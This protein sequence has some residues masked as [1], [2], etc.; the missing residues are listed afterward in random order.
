MFNVKDVFSVS[1]SEN[2]EN[3]ISAELYSLNDSCGIIYITDKANVYIS[4][5]NNSDIEI[6][7]NVGEI[8]DIQ[9][10]IKIYSYKD[11]FA[12]V[13]KYSIKGFVLKLTD[14]KYLLK[15]KRG[16]YHVEH[17]SF[18]IAFYTKDENIFLIHGTD[19]NRLDITNLDTCEL[20]TDR[21]VEYSKEGS[22][23]YLDY[24]HSSLCISP[25]ERH[26]ISNGWVWSP[27]D[28]MYFWKI[29]DFIKGF[30]STLNNLDILARS[31]YNWDRPLCW[32]DSENIAWGYNPNEG[33]EDEI[34]K[35]E[36]TSS[37]IIIQN[38]YDNE[39]VQNK[40]SFNGFSLNEY[41][42]VRG[43]LFYLE[44]YDC[45]MGINN[46]STLTII[47]KNGAVLFEK[48]DIKVIAYNKK[49]K[50]VLTFSGDSELKVLKLIKI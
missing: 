21:V 50:L 8:V 40:I 1:H 19:W 27:Y 13:N 7:K 36:K 47:D 37:E 11:Y 9:S 48:T 28:V 15:L 16:N 10:E 42:E 14:S 38:I 24:F 22:E 4:K 44:D 46:E 5:N 41:S 23:N 31:G 35:D 2:D 29:E 43:E 33:I 34:S 49:L 3:I 17:C 6:I 18:P 12:V 32:I 30:E 26:F 45:F 39:N 20:L 25:D